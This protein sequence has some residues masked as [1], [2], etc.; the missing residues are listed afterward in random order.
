MIKKYIEYLGIESPITENEI[1]V[2]LCGLKFAIKEAERSVA[3]LEQSL[4][5]VKMKKEMEKSNASKKE[6]IIKDKKS[7]N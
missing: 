5:I 3:G 7:E 1:K 2:E 6:S 4:A